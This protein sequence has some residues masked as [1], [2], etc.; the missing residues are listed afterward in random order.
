MSADLTDAEVD[1]IVQRNN[2]KEVETRPY[3]KGERRRRVQAEEQALAA[4]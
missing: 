4:D 1:E 2:F 3:R